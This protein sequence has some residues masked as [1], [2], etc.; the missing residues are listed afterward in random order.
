MPLQHHALAARLHVPQ[1]RGAV[2]GRR[3]DARAVGAE[4]DALQR[5]G[6]ALQ[7]PKL[8]ARARLPEPHRAVVGCGYDMLA[9]GAE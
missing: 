1:A 9:V 7:K 5:T 2:V 3:Q 6:M 8:L 4:R